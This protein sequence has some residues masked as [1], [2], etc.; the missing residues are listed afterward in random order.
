MR[1]AKAQEILSQFHT[2]GPLFHALDNATQ[3]VVVPFIPY[4]ATAKARLGAMLADPADTGAALGAV[5]AFHS[6]FISSVGFARPSDEIDGQQARQVYSVV[7]HLLPEDGDER[8]AIKSALEA[9]SLGAP[10]SEAAVKKDLAR[11]IA[12][13][14]PQ[15]GGNAYG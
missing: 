9:M 8:A 12:A 1:A 15:K 7:Y 13:A 5:A 4:H 2:Q 6:H 3:S 11:I 14:S 10:L